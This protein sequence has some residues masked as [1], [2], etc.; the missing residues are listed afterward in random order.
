ME[1]S[2]TKRQVTTLMTAAFLSLGAAALEAQAPTLVESL[3][4]FDHEF[5]RSDLEPNIVFSQANGGQAD[6]IR[7]ATRPTGEIERALIRQAVGDYV[8]L[9]GTEHRS[10]TVEI[11]V[12]FHIVRRRNGRWNVRDSQIDDQLDVLNDSWMSRG[13]RFTNAGVK[14][15][16]SNRFARKCLTQ[17]VERRFKR[18]NAVDP[19][20]TLNVYTCRPAQGVLGWAYFPSDF[21]ESSTMH[22]VVLHYSTLPGGKAAP[23]NLGDTLTH[24]V[25]HYLGLYHTFEGRCSRRGDRIADTPSERS[26]AY[27]CPTGRDSCPAAGADPILNFMDYSDD[28]CMNT[29]TDDQDSRMQDQVATF[30]P[31]L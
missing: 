18:K 27:G 21:A 3:Q 10:V 9:M 23:Y 13:F 14:R 29:F 16:R 25:G 5:D 12:F 11:R 7:C 30:R 20:H 6:G 28:A 17:R 15:Y 8:E 22:G 4:S 26:P 19:R 24:E 2:V 1:L 31:S